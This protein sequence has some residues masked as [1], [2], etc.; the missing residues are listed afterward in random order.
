MDSSSRI[1]VEMEVFRVAVWYRE[2]GCVPLV[3]LYPTSISTLVPLS[4]LLSTGFSAWTCESLAKSGLCSHG[5][6]R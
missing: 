3:L 2:L 5:W 6:L 1:E 4:V